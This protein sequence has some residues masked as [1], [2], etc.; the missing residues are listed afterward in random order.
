MLSGI[1]VPLITPFTASGEVAYD[2]LEKLAAGALDQGAAGLVALGTTGEP[3]SLTPAE[4]HQVVRICRDVTA[5]YGTQLIVGDV[6]LAEGATAALVTVPA[7]VRPGERGVLAHFERLA[8][9]TPVPLV[10][11]HIPYRT[12]QP[13]TAATLRRLGEHPMITGVKYATGAVDQDAV[14][15]LG[16]LPP[17]FSVLTGD[18]TYLSPMLALGATGGILASAHLHTASFVS[19]AASWDRALGHRLAALSA[20]LFAEPN[21]TVI[22]GVLHA[23]GL[24]PTP[25]V[26]LPLVPAT[27]ESVARALDWGA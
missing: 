1:Y 6:E 27:A 9:R 25:D 24:I 22:K 23:H 17:D 21:P 12:G 15:L 14:A 10:I 5:A 3:S 20:Q 26:R 4:R 2:A 19:M 13:L 18:D 11:Y 8:E 16:D 7:F